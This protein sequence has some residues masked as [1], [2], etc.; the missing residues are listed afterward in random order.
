M[1]DQYFLKIWNW[2]TIKLLDYKGVN[3]YFTQSWVAYGIVREWEALKKCFL[4]LFLYLLVHVV[5]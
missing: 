2:K 5:T 1:I 3:S 4:W